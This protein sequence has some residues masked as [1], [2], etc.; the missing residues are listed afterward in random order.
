MS[1]TLP[2]PASVVDDAFRVTSAAPTGMVGEHPPGEEPT[3]AELMAEI[4]NLKERVH[5][6]ERRVLPDQS[7]GGGHSRLNPPIYDSMSAGE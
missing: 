7:E 3:M 5:N 2:T 4:N 1:N 6:L